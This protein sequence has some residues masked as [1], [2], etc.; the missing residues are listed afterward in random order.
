MHAA[1]LR[2]CTE[3]SIQT[4]RLT[5]RHTGGWIDKQRDECTDGQTGRD[6]HM[7][8]QTDRIIHP[9]SH[10]T[11][12]LVV[13]VHG[14]FSYDASPALPGSPHATLALFEEE[15]F[16]LIPMGFVSLQ[17]MQTVAGRAA[18]AMRGLRK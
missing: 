15:A 17:L 6:T 4:S 1:P 7:D 8:R 18:V 3:T 13:Y 12:I 14:S 5:R 10:S 9:P 2:P 16:L 11:H